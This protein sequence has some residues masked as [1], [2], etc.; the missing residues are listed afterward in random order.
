VDA[1]VLLRVNTYECQSLQSA[2]L[3]LL[4][5]LGETD[6]AYMNLEDSRSRTDFGDVA[7]TNL[8]ATSM[9]FSRGNMVVSARSANAA[10]TSPAEFLHLF[11]S[12]LKAR[13]TPDEKIESMDRF[14]FKEG[15]FSVRDQVPLNLI[16]GEYPG[17]AQYKFFAE[18]GDVFLKGTQLFYEPQAAGLRTILVFGISPEG[19]ARKQELKILIS[20]GVAS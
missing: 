15:K 5:V 11:D 9:L 2:H 10:P 1:D 3:F 6:V 12:S 18:S 19:V 14:R 4:T 20:S 13:P 17:Q 8:E 7:F 16:V